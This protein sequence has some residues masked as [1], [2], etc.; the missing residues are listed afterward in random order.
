M[1]HPL[2]L[3]FP[4]LSQMKKFSIP[5]LMLRHH[6]YDYGVSAVCPDSEAYPKK[7]F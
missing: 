4:R 3:R 1:P 2:N 7:L 5:W 6:L